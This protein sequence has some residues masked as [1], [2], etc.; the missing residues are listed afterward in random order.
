P[1][2]PHRCRVRA[3]RPHPCDGAQPRA[4]RTADAHASLVDPQRPATDGPGDQAGGGE[5]GESGRSG[6]RPARIGRELRPVDGR[7]PGARREE[8]RPCR[9]HPVYDLFGLVSAADRERSRRRNGGVKLHRPRVVNGVIRWIE[10]EEHK[11]TDENPTPEPA[12]PN[13]LDPA[14]PVSNITP[15]PEAATPA[16]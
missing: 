5:R 11:M 6:G 9:L 14:E 15:E 2:R 8:P 4:G 7:R 12:T 1:L 3:A 10:Q 16:D 13:P